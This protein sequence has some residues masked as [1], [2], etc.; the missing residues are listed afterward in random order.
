MNKYYV[1]YVEIYNYYVDDYKSMC[2]NRQKKS[3]F[4]YKYTI[5]EKEEPLTEC[6]IYTIQNKIHQEITSERY[7]YYDFDNTTWYEVAITGIIK[8]EETE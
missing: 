8:L 1:S 5:V 6:L 4:S 3:E 7:K 2:Q